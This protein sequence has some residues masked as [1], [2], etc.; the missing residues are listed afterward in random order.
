MT[1]FDP[2]NQL[3]WEIVQNK[4]DPRRLVPPIESEGLVVL[5]IG[6]GSGQTLMAPELSRA[7]ERHGI[8]IDAMAI[9][10]GQAAFPGLALR[11]APADTVPY[12]DCTF[13]LV[14]SRV[15]LPYTRLPDA[16]SEAYRVLKPRGRI[17]LALHPWR[18]EQERLIEAARRLRVKAVLSRVPVM[19]NS[20]SQHIAGRP[21]P[22]PSFVTRETFQTSRGMRLMLAEAGF[23]AIEVR[24]TPTLIAMAERPAGA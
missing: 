15:A 21:L 20:V 13:D 10:R 4:D 16:L 17:W 11:V 22:L 24:E 12:P 18:V 3:E 6:C 2:Y 14:Y 1:E 5:D 19:A 7:R 23:T 8:D 9:A